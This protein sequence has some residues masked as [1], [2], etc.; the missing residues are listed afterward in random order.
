[1]ISI[2]RGLVR[3]PVFAII[4]VLTLGLGIGANTAIFSIVNALLLRPLPYDHPDRLVLVWGTT[5]KV[6]R[7]SISP[8]NFL[9]YQDQNRV[10]EQMATFNGTDVILT[11]VIDPERVHG[12][13]VTPNFFAVL[14]VQPIYG[15]N[16]RPE[17][18]QVGHTDVVILSYGFWRRRFAANTSAIGQTIS[19]NSKPYTIIGVMPDSFEF[20]VPGFF[21]PA[22]IW[23]PAALVRD[24]KQRAR[25]YLRTLARL[26]PDIT[27]QQAKSDL[28]SISSQL[29]RLYPAANDGLGA[30]IV[31]L[32]EQMTE[33][34]RRP[35]LFL[36]GAVS[37]VLLIACANV[38]NLQLERAVLRQKEIAVRVALGA[39]H[40]RIAGELLAESMIIALAAGIV[41]VV[42]AVV[43]LGTM[44]ANFANVLPVGGDHVLDLKILAFT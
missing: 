40:S 25:N 20:S 30:D 42:L 28:N 26:K 43:G 12:G 7:A 13:R 32:H 3:S 9:D 11:G 27:I 1:F 16:F 44:K 6:K 8:P 21:R 24:D 15:R 22:E 31:S 33:G 23:S 35:L 29:S 37:F 41:G 17:D 14:G 36:L 18:G 2:L 19:L 5:P 34:S 38:A 39:S 4:A 10:F